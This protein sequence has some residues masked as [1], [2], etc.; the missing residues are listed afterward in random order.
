MIHD[1]PCIYIYI[2]VRRKNDIRF[3][4]DYSFSSLRFFFRPFQVF[5][6][7]TKIIFHVL[8]EIPFPRLCA[9]QFSVARVQENYGNGISSIGR[10][11]KK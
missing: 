5:S 6:F 8:N 10:K 3:R 2:H 11:A 4:Q 1:T 7:G 9:R